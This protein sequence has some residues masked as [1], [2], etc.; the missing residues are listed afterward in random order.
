MFWKN[1]YN[2]GGIYRNFQ[3]PFGLINSYI[4]GSILYLHYCDYSSDLTNTNPIYNGISFLNYRGA[5][6]IM[7]Q[8]IDNLIDDINCDS[9]DQ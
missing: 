5:F 3:I 4:H 8:N 2:F 7:N 6:Y 9:F 1:V